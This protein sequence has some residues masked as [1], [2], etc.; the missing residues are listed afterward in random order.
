MDTKHEVKNILLGNYEEENNVIV[1][2]KR[3]D[4]ILGSMSID[5]LRTKVFGAVKLEQRVSFDKGKGKKLSEAIAKEMADLGQPL[6]LS[7]KPEAISCFIKNWWTNPIIICAEVKDEEGVLKL[8]AWS[9]RMFLART[10]LFRLLRKLEKS[11]PYLKEILPKEKVKK[12]KVKKQKEPG[13]KFKKLKDLG[14]KFKKRREKTEE[15]GTEAVKTTVP[16]D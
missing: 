10:R 8:T 13:D 15:T 11:L 16:E 9:C 7:T 2:T 5:W 3:D 4:R 12:E 6:F 14:K 1:E